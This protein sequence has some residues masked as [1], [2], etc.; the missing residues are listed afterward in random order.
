M[1]VIVAG[2]TGFLGAEVMRQLTARA[3]VDGVTCLT[4]RPVEAAPAKV[5]SVV[6]EDFLSYDAELARDLS[7]HAA[8]VWALG[9]RHA[10]GGD[11]ALHARAT[12]DYPLALLH[13]VMGNDPVRFRFCYVSGWGSDPVRGAT[14]PFLPAGA[15]LKGRAEGRLND[16]AAERPGLEVAS[17]RPAK[18]LPASAGALTHAFYGRL[19][20]GV[21]ELARALIHVALDAPA[22][23]TP[24][25]LTNAGLRALARGR[26]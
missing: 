1:R 23:A 15:A 20:V 25:A 2:A 8:C 10:P 3:D 26:A 12:I 9:S 19:W 6:M 22:G 7:G 21:D 4:R 18:I 17:F 13:A 11:A 16:F 14:M 5:T 24:A